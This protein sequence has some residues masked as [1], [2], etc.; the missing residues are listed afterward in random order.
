MHGEP[1]LL[2]FGDEPIARIRDA[3]RASVRDQG[4]RQALIQNAAHQRP[5]LFGLDV[6]VIADELFLAYA[7]M[8]QQ[9]PR[10]PGILGRDEINLFER[11]DDAV[12]QIVQIADGRSDDIERGG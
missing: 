10:A 2:R 8:G 4:C 5:R 3:G 6:I 11:A 1:G 9:T 7:A 12:A